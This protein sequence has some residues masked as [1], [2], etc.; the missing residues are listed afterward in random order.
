M[1]YYHDGPDDSKH[2]RHWIGVAHR[3][4]LDICLNRD[5]GEGRLE[6]SKRRLWKRLWW[7]L[8]L[9]DRACALGMR[10]YP[11]IDSEDCKWSELD[12]GDFG[13]RTASRDLLTAFHGCQMLP[14]LLL[15]QELAEICIAQIQLWQQLA[16]IME[17]RYRP[18]SPRYGST[19][20]TTLILVPQSTP[21]Q[22]QEHGLCEE[23]LQSWVT[24]F[25]QEFK[26]PCQW[27]LSSSLETRPRVLIVHACMV[28]LLYH[29][30]Q[31]ALYRPTPNSTAETATE[32]ATSRFKARTSAALIISIFEYI[33]ALDLLGSMPGWSVTMLTQAALTLKDFFNDTPSQIIRKLQDCMDILE[34]LRQQHLHAAFGVSVISSFIASRDAKAKKSSGVS[35]MESG[36]GSEPRHPPSTLEVAQDLSPYSLQFS[37]YQGH[38][39][40]FDESALLPTGMVSP[41]FTEFFDREL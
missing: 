32:N 10:Q 1:T 26:F 2:L 14:D 20:E 6:P 34:L 28:N 11:I 12:V 19:H 17:L 15:Q 33:Q 21:P 38:L 37:T 7:C 30:L 5:M 41:W 29:A 31:C 24:K 13:L 8:F 22:S 36:V 18:R 39:E 23:R 25:S 40:D 35:S 3:Q 16:G 4:A 9:R 27:P